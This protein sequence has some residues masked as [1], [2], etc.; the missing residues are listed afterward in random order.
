MAVRHD[1]RDDEWE[2][3]KGLLPGGKRPGRPWRSHRQVINGMLWILAT[4]AAWRDLPKRYGPWQSVYDRFNRW[5][6]DGTLQRIFEAIR[7][8]LDRQGLIDWDLWCVDGASVR[9]SRAAAGGG[10]RGATGSR[11]TTRSAT[12]AEASERS[13]IC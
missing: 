3:L 1:L 9:A 11:R 4:G 6:S 13:S 7:D 10:K 5:R 12:R 2:R 8:D